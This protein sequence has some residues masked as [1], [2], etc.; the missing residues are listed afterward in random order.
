MEGNGT[1]VL[2]PL[3]MGSLQ[4]IPIEELVA[5]RKKVLEVMERVME[6][7]VHYGKIPGT[8]KPTL[9]KPGAEVLCM[10]FMLAPKY[11][12]IEREREDSHLA[13][14][15]LCTL[16][17]IPTGV[18]VGSGRGSC[19]TRES[20][21]AYRKGSRT[22]PACGAVGTI[23]KSKF[24][25]KGK[26]NAE[27]GWY[28]HKNGGC[29]AEFEKGHEA[30]ESQDVGRV[31]NPDVADQENTVLKMSD[32]RSLIAAVLNTLACSDVFTQDLEDTA[33]EDRDAQPRP[34]QGAPQS[35]GP[36]GGQPRQQPQGGQ[37]RPAGAPQ[38]PKPSD[39]FAGGG[40]G[41][42]Q[43]NGDPRG[44]IVANILNVRGSFAT[45]PKPTSW[46]AIQTHFL[47]QT[48]TDDLMTTAS[49]ESLTK[50]L[51]FLEALAAGDADSVAKLSDIIKGT[52]R[53]ED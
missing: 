37:Q 32:K 5:R 17:H 44:E 35:R 22:C 11:E 24:P 48:Y 47:K 12:T 40:N 16:I 46:A 23:N 53:P 27:P 51:R 39:P 6:D 30:I 7:G 4:T 26:P 15:S 38:A 36:Q 1:A 13:I 3:A 18:F 52:A 19:S 43:S 34:S 42:A 31:A 29:G 14:T 25:P 50:M 49:P 20:K 33:H 41:A 2:T 9:L 8:P 21:Y 45:P 28:C 10:T